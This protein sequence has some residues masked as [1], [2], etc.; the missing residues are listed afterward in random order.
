MLVGY[1][2]VFVIRIDRLVLWWY[3]DLLD[4]EFQAGKVLEKVGVMRVME[5]EVCE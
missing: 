2:I 5:V 3:V 1:N 4:R